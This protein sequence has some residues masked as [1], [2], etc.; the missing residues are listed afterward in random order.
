MPLS[1]PPPPRDGRC[2]SPPVGLGGAGAAAAAAMG[3]GAAAEHAAGIYSPGAVPAAAARPRRGRL[4][5]GLRT[6]TGE[7]GAGHATPDRD[8]AA[9]S[10]V[11]VGAAPGRVWA[12][13]APAPGSVRH[14]GWARH[15]YGLDPTPGSVRHRCRHCWAPGLGIVQPWL[16]TSTG[17]RARY[18]SVSRQW[19]SW[20]WKSAL[21]WRGRWEM[22]S[23]GRVGSLGSAEKVTG[24]SPG[25]AGLGA[26]V[27]AVS[28]GVLGRVAVTAT[29]LPT[30]LLAFRHFH[31]IDKAGRGLAAQ[32]AAAG[33]A[34]ATLLPQSLVLGFLQLECQPQRLHLHV[35]AWVS[36]G[37]SRGGRNQVSR[38]HPTPGLE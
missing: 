35:G 11:R 13:T 9:R 27:A 37:S 29:S 22:R 6:G 4:R 2:A 33:G 32:G 31:G 28:R 36:H 26:A 15:R 14:R 34:A 8:E 18:S 16:G 23:W 24:G 1:P 30:S 17:H 38:F 7:G 12:G 10:S 5:H 3:A 21:P 20:C 19:R 25:K